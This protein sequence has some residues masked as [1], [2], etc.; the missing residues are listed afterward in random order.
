MKS[1][2]IAI[3]LFVFVGGVY[4]LFTWAGS[5]IGGD[6]SDSSLYCKDRQI[7]IWE[8]TDWGGYVHCV[9]PDDWIDAPSGYHWENR[10]T[11][12]EDEYGILFL[13]GDFYSILAPEYDYQISVDD[14]DNIHLYINT[15]MEI[16]LKPNQVK[17]D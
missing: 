15:P 6:Y 13:D 12:F 16:I 7:L 8:E 17:E 10:D 2:I 3:V 1:L 11:P 14:E 5:L 4:P 9:Y